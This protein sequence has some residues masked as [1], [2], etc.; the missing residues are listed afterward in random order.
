M[1]RSQR[2]KSS[3]EIHNVVDMVA[4]WDHDT[5]QCP[6]LV[7]IIFSVFS[8]PPKASSLS[9]GDKRPWTINDDHGTSRIQDLISAVDHGSNFHSANH[10][11]STEKKKP[12]NRNIGRTDGTTCACAEMYLLADYYCTT[13]QLGVLCHCQLCWNLGVLDGI[14]S[15]HA[16]S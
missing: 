12:A 14:K 15:Y 5:S 2:S 3:T 7:F 13:E 4:S 9:S 1:D 8:H 16:I 10:C 6:R 11:R